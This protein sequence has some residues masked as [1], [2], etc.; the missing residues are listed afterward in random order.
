M[1]FGNRSDFRLPG[2]Q[3]IEPAPCLYSKPYSYDLLIVST[4]PTSAET[5]L[6]AS[7]ESPHGRDGN[8][9]GLVRELGRDG[10]DLWNR[11]GR[12]VTAE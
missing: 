2:T 11:L 6:T 9:P 1:S 4:N 3:R 5:C 8:S 12:D 7:D 10:E